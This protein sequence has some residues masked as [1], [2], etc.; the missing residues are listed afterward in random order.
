MITFHELAKISGKH[1]FVAAAG[2]YNDLL[3]LQI[4]CMTHSDPH[5][6]MTSV[7]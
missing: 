7:S 4:Y 2:L 3:Q 6:Y 5:A 1:H